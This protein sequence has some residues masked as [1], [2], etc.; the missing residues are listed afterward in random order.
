[1]SEIPHCDR[2]P[3]RCHCGPE[4]CNNE[5]YNRLERELAEAR[6]A[7]YIERLRAENAE[8]R[9]ILHEVRRNARSCD[10]MGARDSS[11]N[12]TDLAARIDA[13]LRGEPF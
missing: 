5:H 11:G 10:L 1:M 2:W 4:G 8:L 9:E 7:M 6:S 13:A 12:L 3:N